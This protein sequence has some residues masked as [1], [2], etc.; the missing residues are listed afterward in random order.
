MKKIP[1]LCCALLGTALL[2]TL[3]SELAFA[4]S[5]SGR[6]ISDPDG[7]GIQGAQVGVYNKRWK[8]LYKKHTDSSGN[9]TVEGLPTGSYYLHT[10]N[11]KGYIDK[12]YDNLPVPGTTWPPEGATPVSVKKG[13]NTPNINFRL[14]KGG[15]ISGRVTRDSDGDP[16]KDVTVGV[17]TPDWNLF[18]EVKTDVSGSYTAPGLPSGGYFVKVSNNQGYIEEYYDDVTVEDRAA[19][20]TVKQG[21]ATPGVNF[22]LSPGGSISG[23]VIRDLDGAGIEGVEVKIYDTT[24]KLI[25]SAHTRS[26]GDYRIDGLSG[27]DYYASTR[28]AWNYVDMFYDNVLHRDKSKRI[29]VRQGENTSDINLSLVPGGT[30]SGR[31]AGEPDG[32]GLRNVYMI[33]YDKEW[34]YVNGAEVSL[35]GHYTVGKLPRGSYYVQTSNNQGYVDEYYDDVT[36]RDKAK[37]IKVDRGAE[38]SNINFNIRKEAQ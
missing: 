30:I 25:R 12:F 35:T 24:W 38:V 21:I 27:G 32:K 4:G 14:P 33:V 9:Y 16:V 15:S 31:V 3:F 2:F 13:S 19:L 1:G 26:S 18:K 5:I 10:I 36:S 17:Y 20:V 37:E 22:G 8:P 7:K 11:D 29:T 34:S 28:N 6:V 23:R